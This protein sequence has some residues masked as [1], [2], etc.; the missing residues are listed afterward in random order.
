MGLFDAPTGGQAT[1]LTSGSPEYQ[2]AIVQNTT[3]KL[4]P[5]Y[6]QALKSSQQSFSGRGLLDSGLGAQAEL[7]LQ[8]GYLGQIGDVATQAATQGADLAEQNRQREQQRGWQV[9]DRDL[10]LQMLRDQANQ[11]QSNAGQAAWANLI[12]SGVGAAGRLAGGMLAGPAAPAGV[13]AGGAIGDALG[14]AIS[15]GLYPKT[16][17]PNNPY[18]L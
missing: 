6:Q 18:G 1:N 16:S 7:G 5:A 15:G 17:D 13:A 10:N 11:A 2:N 9:E 4:K 12:G 8:Q 3:N 14:G